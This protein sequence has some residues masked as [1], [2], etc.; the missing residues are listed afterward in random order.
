MKLSKRFALPGRRSLMAYVDVS[1]PFNRKRMNGSGLSSVASANYLE[2][3]YTLR[4]EGSDVK[5]GDSSTFNV[6]SEP[7]KDSNDIWQP[8]IAPG[9]DWL[10]FQ[11]PRLVRFGMT[12]SL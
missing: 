2:H 10:L 5:Y 9:I 12:F 4:Q 7:Y 11:N 3:V 8:P 1:N 6:F